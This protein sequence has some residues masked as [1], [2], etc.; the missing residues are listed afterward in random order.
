[1]IKKYIAVCYG[2]ILLFRLIMYCLYYLPALSPRFVNR[3]LLTYIIV[4]RESFIY[5]L[6]CVYPGP[7]A[8]ANRVSW[9][10]GGHGGQSGRRILYSSDRGE[11]PRLAGTDTPTSTLTLQLPPS[12]LS[13]TYLHTHSG[14]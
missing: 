9:S 10:R 8:A 5:L 4:R 6:H 12:P 14:S 13:L 7:D 2:C 11:S 3:R 1:M